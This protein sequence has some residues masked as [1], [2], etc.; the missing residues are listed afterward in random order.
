[1]STRKIV[2]NACFGGFGLSTK[3]F[4]RYKEL[5]G[6]DDKRFY[7]RTILR[8]DPILVQIV[9]DMGDE[10]SGGYAELRVVEIPDDVEWEIAEYDGYEHVAEAHRIW[11]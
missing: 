10:A 4:E 8:D 5:K 3:A 6:V 2:I 7:D 11:P 1:M 9:E